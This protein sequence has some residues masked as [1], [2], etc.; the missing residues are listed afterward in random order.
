MTPV[1]GG[2]DQGGLGLGSGMNAFGDEGRVFRR[3]LE[4]E[5]GFEYPRRVEHA[6]AAA[7]E[8]SFFDDDR[9]RDDRVEEKEALATI[10]AGNHARFDT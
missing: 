7:T 2:Y 1:A 6:R 8:H 3:F 5:L 4:Y 10:E 9:R